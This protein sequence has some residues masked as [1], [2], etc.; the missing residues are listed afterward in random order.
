MQLI[1]FDIDGT[2]TESNDLDNQSFLQALSELWGFSDISDDWPSYSHVTDACIFREAFLQKLGRP[3][4][5]LEVNTFQRHFLKLLTEGAKANGGIKP[6]PGA[7]KLLS[8]LI[9][10]SNHAVAY[11]GGSWTAAA[12]FKLRSA[13]LPIQIIPYAF[14]DDDESREGIMAIAL[15]RA[16]TYY[17][18]SFSNVVYVGDGIWDVRSAR[19]SGYGF[20]GIA[21][22]NQANVLFSEGAT[23]VLP[24]YDNSERFLAAL[25]E[26]IA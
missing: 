13:Q 1:M 20:V 22:G 5:P 15:A 6:I 18:Q 14:S 17:G 25:V 24:N 2:L 4:S 9:E 21:S 16:E 7:L 23:H 10:S 3:P 26:N 19:K 8:W 12:L 11:A